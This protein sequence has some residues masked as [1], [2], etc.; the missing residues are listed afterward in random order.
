M[1]FSC[2]AWAALAPQGVSHK[3]S[4]AVLWCLAPGHSR[5]ILWV[6]W[7]MGWGLMYCTCLSGA[8][9]GYSLGLS[10]VEFEG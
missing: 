1:G 8:F 9:H 5:L 4:G 7:V 2:A 10:S 3:I 6:P